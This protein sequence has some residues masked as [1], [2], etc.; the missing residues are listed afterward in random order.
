MVSPELVIVS[1]P[2]LRVQASSFC[3]P[4]A[5]PVPVKSGIDGGTRRSI[6]EC[7]RCRGSRL[8]ESE[9]ET[10]G[11]ERYGFSNAF[12]GAPACDPGSC[13][14]RREIRDTDPGTVV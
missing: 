8:H 1:P 13:P 4:H 5:R 12:P 14:L 7:K 3:L 2:A 6:R 9:A 10:K 11:I